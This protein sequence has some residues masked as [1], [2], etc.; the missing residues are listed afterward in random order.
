MARPTTRAP[1]T[2]D[3][4]RVLL[5][6]GYVDHRGRAHTEVALAPLTGTA[7]HALAGRA[8]GASV[9]A[10]T[11]FVLAHAIVSIGSI[12]RVTPELVRAL[13]VQDRDYLLGRLR[14]LTVGPRM[15]VRLHCSS[16]GQDMELNLR[17]DDLPVIRRPVQAR[18]FT[19]DGGLEL[20][21]PNGGDQE[22]AAASGLLGAPELRAAMLARC[23]RPS[24]GGRADRSEERMR[25][26]GPT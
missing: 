21:L 19:F 11:T 14:A 1:R 25:A 24:R 3:V 22:W 23:L 15:W 18:Y 6:G 8:P 13:L 17:L 7:E 20:R 12:R 5:P 2:A 10:L 9:A 4:H 26:L 16:C